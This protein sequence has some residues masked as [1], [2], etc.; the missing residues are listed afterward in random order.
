M[1]L[2]ANISEEIKN[3]NYTLA[4]QRKGRSLVWIISGLS[5]IVRPDKSILAVLCIAELAQKF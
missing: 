4:G 5:E 3:G 1:D 2:N